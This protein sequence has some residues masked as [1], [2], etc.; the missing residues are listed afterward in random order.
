MPSDEEIEAAGRVLF[1]PDW[2]QH[3]ADI[4]DA[5]NAADLAKNT[6]DSQDIE[7]QV[8]ELLDALQQERGRNDIRGVNARAEFIIRRLMRERRRFMANSPPNSP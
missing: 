8:A 1:G 6:R 3:A 4:S 5:L 2:A 7:S